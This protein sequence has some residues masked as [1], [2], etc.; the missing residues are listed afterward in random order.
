AS[1]PPC[2]SGSEH[3]AALPARDPAGR[4]PASA[5]PPPGTGAR[6][7]QFDRDV[8]ERRC[9]LDEAVLSQE[10]SETLVASAIQR[11]WALGETRR[12]VRPRLPVQLIVEVGISADEELPTLLRMIGEIDRA[13]LDHVQKAGEAVVRHQVRAGDEDQFVIDGDAVILGKERLALMTLQP[14]LR[15]LEIAIAANGRLDLTA[16]QRCGQREV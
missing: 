3:A 11:G 10:L 13:L 1:A 12:R 5:N 15:Q 8:V 14:H 2:S 16:D 6:S 9:G 4:R 7:S